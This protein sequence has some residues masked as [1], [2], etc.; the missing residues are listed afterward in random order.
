MATEIIYTDGA[1]SKNGTAKSTGGFGLY[2]SQ[3]KFS[4][5]PVKI[6][7]KGFHMNFR[8]NDYE[9]PLY[10]VTNIRMEG[11]AIVSVF[12]LY[13]DLLVFKKPKKSNISFVDT[14]NTADV[15]LQSDQTKQLKKTPIDPDVEIEIVT[16]SQF[17]INVIKLWMP[18]WIKKNIMMEKK[19][20][21]ILL[22]LKYYLDLFE[23]NNIRFK[24]TH[25]KSHQKGKKTFH[26][27]GNEIADE[28]ATSSVTNTD[29]QYTLIN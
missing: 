7:R 4:K 26:A 18:N 20:P 14:L 2:I 16:D 12:A 27:F 24:F 23:V 3:S 6:N 10:Y 28:L 17:W 13:A 1:C 29:T 25:V 22:M 8:L 19:N 21:D 15:F 5:T 9:T 11:L